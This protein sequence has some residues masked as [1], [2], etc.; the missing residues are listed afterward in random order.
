MSVTNKQPATKVAGL[1][2]ARLAD[3][4]LDH[5]ECMVQYV[6]REDTDDALYG[7]DHKYWEK[8]IRALVETHDLVTTQRYRVMMLLDLLERNALIRTHSR[9]AA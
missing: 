4:Q 1:L 5:F 6:I 9:T 2:P 3:D 8:R 7:F